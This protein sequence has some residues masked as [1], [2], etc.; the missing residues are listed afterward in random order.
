[1]QKDKSKREWHVD[2]FNVT[3]VI[4]KQADGGYKHIANCSFDYKSQENLELN[5][6][7]ARLISASP[8]MYEALKTCYKSLCTYGRH[9]IIENMV[10][11]ILAKVE[12]K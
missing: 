8:D 1:M 7:N 10:E 5:H 2:G 11:K 4:E 6:S 3:S 9:P 12:G